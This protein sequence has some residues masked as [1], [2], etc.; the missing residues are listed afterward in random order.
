MKLD[1]Y[2]VVMIS[3]IVIIFVMVFFTWQVFQYHS[4]MEAHNDMLYCMA[5]TIRN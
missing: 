1:P 4:C 2:L 5:Q 3:M